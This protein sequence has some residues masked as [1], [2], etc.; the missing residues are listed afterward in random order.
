MSAPRHGRRNWT[1]Y[2]DSAGRSG[3]RCKMLQEWTAVRGM[4]RTCP[5]T[6]IEWRPIAAARHQQTRRPISS[7]LAYPRRTRRLGPDTREA[8]S[9]KPLAAQ[10]ARTPSSKCRRRRARQ[11]ERADRMELARQRH[12]LRSASNRQL[13][14]TAAKHPGNRQPTRFPP[15]IATIGSDGETVTPSI[16]EPDVWTGMA[17]ANALGALRWKRAKIHRGSRQ[18]LFRPHHEAG[19][20]S[21]VV[22]ESRNCQSRCNRAGSIYVHPISSTGA[23]ANHR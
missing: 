3:W 20:T 15:A 19:Y 21:A 17:R 9:E 13:G 1:Y 5:E 16:P 22:T 23:A 18:E 6:T 14:L 2:C 12:E 8:G 10:S 7:Y 4:D 11:Q